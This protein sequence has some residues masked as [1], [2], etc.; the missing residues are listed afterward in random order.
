MPSDAVAAEAVLERLNLPPRLSALLQGES[1]LNDASGLVLFRLAVAAALTG[2]F[3]AGSAIGAFCIL[4]G[5]GTAF[6]LVI[7]YEGRFVIHRLHASELVITATL[8]LTAFSYIGGERLHVSGVLATVA[9]GLLIGWH[10]HS[11][12]TAATRIRGQTFWKVTVFLL[13]SLLFI[14]IGLSLRGLVER[15]GLSGHATHVLLVPALGVVGAVVLS[16]FAWVTGSCLNLRTMHR[17]GFTHRRGQVRPW[18]P[19]P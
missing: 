2:D 3:S 14:L 7:G 16:R 5:G 15:V 12:I 11:A 9:T 19:R 1:L 8:L 18:L 6:G 17:L 4:A 13:Q 10:Q